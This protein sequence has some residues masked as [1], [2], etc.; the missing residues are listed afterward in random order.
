MLFAVLAVLHKGANIAPF[1]L[2]EFNAVN[3]LAI[4]HSHV[5]PLCLI[6]SGRDLVR[7]GITCYA[8]KNP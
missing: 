4:A 3:L 8:A 6:R 1:V 7:D 5:I 2:Y